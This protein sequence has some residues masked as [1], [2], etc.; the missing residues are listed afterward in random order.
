MTLLP[1][2]LSRFSDFLAVCSI[3][4]KHHFADA[5]L[6]SLSDQ[7]KRHRHRAMPARLRYGE[8]VLDAVIQP[9]FM[10]YHA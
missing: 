9:R 3:R 5:R 7:I 2:D 1:L 8:T 10:R 6:E 4:W